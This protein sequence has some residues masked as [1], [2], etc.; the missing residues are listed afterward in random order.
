MVGE[1]NVELLHLVVEMIYKQTCTNLKQ[2]I[3][4]FVEFST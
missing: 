3:L 2:E 1:K 4:Y